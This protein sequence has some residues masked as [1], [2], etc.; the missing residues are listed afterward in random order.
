MQRRR[1]LRAAVATG[2]GWSLGAGG[3]ALRSREAELR[4]VF[5]TD[6]HARLEKRAPEGVERAAAAI[7]AERADLVIN[8]GD[9]I[10]GGFDLTSAQAAPRWEVYLTMQRAIQGEIHSTLGNH[11][12]VGVAPRDGSAP[13]PDPRADFRAA[14]GLAQTWYSFDAAGY[15]FV[16]LD[17]VHI[18]GV[19]PPY[20]G[21][22]GAEQMDWL[23][24][25][26]AALPVGARVIAV[27]HMPLLTAFFGAVEGATARAPSNR[28]VGNNVEVLQAFARHR[29]VLVLQG[30]LHVNEL[31]RWRHTTFITGGAIC[32]RWWRGPNHGTEEGFGV[33]T[34]RGDQAG[35]RYVDYGWEIS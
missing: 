26:L 6:V 9:L 8:G 1:F 15:H 11:D 3:C 2:L 23:R 24:G 12:L 32:G 29:L 21:H 19:Q 17:S 22:I 30:H 13:N 31:L 28:V 27:T 10:H 35:W 34:L 4:I 7:N 20:E 14:T 5:Y 18:T 25:D 16:V 33:V